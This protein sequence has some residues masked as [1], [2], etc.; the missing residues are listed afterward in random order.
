MTLDLAAILEAEEVPPTTVQL[1]LS[2]RMVTI[3]TLRRT[4][5]RAAGDVPRDRHCWAPNKPSLEWEGRATWAGY[6]LVRLLERAGWDARWI[7]NWA[8][9]REFCTEVGKP[10]A[11]PRAAGD[12]F[13]RL[14]RRAAALRGAGSWDIFGWKAGEYLFLESKKHASGDRLNQNQIAWL[15]AATVEGFRPEQFA[16][17]E[18]RIPR[19]AAVPA[20]ECR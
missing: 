16:V 9:G 13:E 2:G 4:E 18:Y 1:P 7:K 12:V 10:N 5:H 17:V 19:L 15:E 20:S 6:V 14:H 3:R 11:L 8:G